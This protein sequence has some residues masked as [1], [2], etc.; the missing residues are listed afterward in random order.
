MLPRF[1]YAISHCPGRFF[2]N[3]MHLRRAGAQQLAAQQV[4]QPVNVP[5]QE[6]D[7]D[8]SAACPLFISIE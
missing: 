4:T 7:S 8:D 3:M 6:G 2:S 1:G 5:H